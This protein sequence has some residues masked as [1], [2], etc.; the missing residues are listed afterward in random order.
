M[1]ITQLLSH[2]AT[3]VTFADPIEPDF[4]VRFKTTRNTKSLNGVSVD[5]YLHEIIVNDTNPVT[6]GNTSANDAL[7]VRVRISGSVNSQARLKEI[8]KSLAG[9]LPSWADENAMVGFEPV[10]LPI[11]P[12]V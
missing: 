1:S 12:V 9:Q 4:T 7:S 6:I 2:D 5:N 10:T 3:G 11:N 8:V